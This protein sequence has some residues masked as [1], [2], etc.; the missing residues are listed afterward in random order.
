MD[1]VKSQC[2]AEVCI[3]VVFLFVFDEHRV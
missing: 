3:C 1:K 2:Y